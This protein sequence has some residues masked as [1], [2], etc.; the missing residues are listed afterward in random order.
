LPVLRHDIKHNKLSSKN[1]PTNTI[2]STI[3]TRFGPFHASFPT[4]VTKTVGPTRVTRSFVSGVA[5]SAQASTKVMLKR[6]GLPRA[7][8]KVD[9][10]VKG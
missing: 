10:M 3:V 8:R 7:E 9:G 6:A 2:G 1:P 4:G 5:S